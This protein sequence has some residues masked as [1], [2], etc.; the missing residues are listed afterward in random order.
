[1]LPPRGEGWLVHSH[2]DGL[3]PHVGAFAI[4]RASAAR[5][6]DS[7]APRPTRTS[8]P[9]RTTPT[10]VP[11][12]PSATHPK[13]FAHHR[14]APDPQFERTS[15][16]WLAASEEEGASPN[17]TETNL[18]G[19]LAYGHLVRKKEFRVHLPSLLE[20]KSETRKRPIEQRSRCANDGRWENQTSL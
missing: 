2:R 7:S 4:A 8:R 1:M 6:S 19:L 17:S 9:G 3:V 5:V 13:L 16:G 20:T 18:L 10:R 12:S 14:S 15:Q 11:R